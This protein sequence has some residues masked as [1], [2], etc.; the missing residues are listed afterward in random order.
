MGLSY[1]AQ[2]RTHSRRRGRRWRELATLRQVGDIEREL[3]RREEDAQVCGA[4]AETSAIMIHLESEP[5][6][7]FR[8]VQGGSGFRVVQGL[9]FRHAGTGEGE[10]IACNA[11]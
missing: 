8:V 5:G 1:W 6:S 11:P 7:G 3:K 2:G 9:G 10:R 4:G